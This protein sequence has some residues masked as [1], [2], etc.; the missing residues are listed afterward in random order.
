[1]WGDEHWLLGLGAVHML[2]FWGL[3]VL[4]IVA[5]VKVLFGSENRR[6]DTPDPRTPLE[7]LQARYAR[8]EIGREEYNRKRE[9]M[10]AS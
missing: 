7:I 8:G 6:A 4:A 1:M 9:D 10:R 2:L 5:L 3:I